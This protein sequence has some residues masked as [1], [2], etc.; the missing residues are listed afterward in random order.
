MIALFILFFAMVHFLDL[1]Y[2]YLIL[3]RFSKKYKNP[4]VLELNF[5]KYFIK[6][7]GLEKGLLISGN[8]SMFFILLAV[9]LNL[10]NMFAIGF[11]LG[12]IITPA[13]TNIRTYY[14]K[15]KLVSK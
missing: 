10:Y 15:E 14:H 3:K 1:L 8:I 13:I 6:N 4:E 11:I 9:I 7:F 2:T 12:V 5:H